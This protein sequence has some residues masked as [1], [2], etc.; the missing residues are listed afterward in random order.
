[1]HNTHHANLKITKRG[2]AVPI[3]RI[4]MIKQKHHRNQPTT[5]QGIKHPERPVNIPPGNQSSA[6]M[7]Y[8]SQSDS[9]VRG[10][11]VLDRKKV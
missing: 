4:D 9:S 6:V 3:L 5:K 1:M 11:F 2:Q 8:G 10:V 7:D